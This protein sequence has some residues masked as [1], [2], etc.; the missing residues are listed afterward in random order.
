MSV[1]TEMA[2]RASGA[3]Q[4]FNDKTALRDNQKAYFGTDGDSSAKFNATDN[5]LEFEGK[6]ARFT[7]GQKRKVTS[8]AIDLSPTAAQVMHGHIL[9]TV[10]AMTVSL[11]APAAAVEG[12]DVL[13]S[14]VGDIGTTVNVTG[15][16]GFGNGGADKDVATVAEGTTGHF[17]C[18]STD[19]GTT[20]YWFMVSGPSL[21]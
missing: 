20:F 2:D 14:P 1:T 16:T 21:A 18:S 9:V 3:F 12:A 8:T 11:P 19:A 5:T 17:V 10:T 13:V 7:G 15:G 6:G 4:V